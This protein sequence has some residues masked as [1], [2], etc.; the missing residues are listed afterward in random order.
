M[1]HDEVRQVR[2]IG[3]SGSVVTEHAQLAKKV[4]SVTFRVGRGG[5]PLPL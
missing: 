2:E 1:S 3:E 4:A 5:K